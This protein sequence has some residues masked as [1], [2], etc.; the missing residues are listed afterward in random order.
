M[1]STLA[2]LGLGDLGDDADLT[3]LLDAAR[4]QARLLASYAGYRALRWR[5]ESGA[6]LTL[7]EHGEGP[8]AELVDLVPSYDGPHGVRLG[9]LTGRGSYVAAS[10][11]AAD[12]DGTVRTTLVVDLAQGLLPPDGL[13]PPRDAALTAL[14]TD[15]ACFADAAAFAVSARSAVR[16]TLPSAP[17]D[18]RFS[19]ETLLSTGLF[20]APDA[21]TPTAFLSGTVLTST[22]RTTDARERAFHAV[23]VRCLGQVVTVC[24]DADDHEAP[25]VGAT[26]A[27]DCYLV[28]DVPGL[29]AP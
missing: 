23:Q 8:G 27:G 16:A 24:L 22:T 28:A 25:P 10:L 14:G 29:W 11:L 13:E 17:A 2:C 18:A 3:A 7:V 5:D 6:C 9:G 1:T 19:P 20:A 26:L 15:V 21:A 12:G 4:P